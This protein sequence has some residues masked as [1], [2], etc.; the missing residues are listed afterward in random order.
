MILAKDRETPCL[1]YICAGLCTKGRK[2]DHGHYCQRC[3]KYKP[4]AKVRHLNRKKQELDKI[5]KN[6]R[7]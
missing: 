4:R 7:Y 2:A 6:E 5:R 3:D 1:H